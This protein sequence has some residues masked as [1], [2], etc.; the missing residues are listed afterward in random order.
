MWTPDL[1]A[2]TAIDEI[3]TSLGGSKLKIVV[4]DEVSMLSMQFLVLFDSQL[5]AM[6]KPEK[7]I[8]LVISFNFQL[9]LDV[10]FGVSCMAMSR[11][12]MRQHIISFNC[13]AF[14]N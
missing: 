11:V 2:S 12:M 5:Q 8:R 9:H 14:M 6:Y 7:T 10:I 13:F 1:S 3:Q 4:V